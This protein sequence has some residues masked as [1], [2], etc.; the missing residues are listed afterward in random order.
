MAKKKATKKK[1]TKKAA[2]KT[3]AKKASKKEVLIVG[4]KMKDAIRAHGCNV[5]GD[6]IEGLNEY[7][8]W[9]LDQA[10]ARAK[11]NGRKTVRKHD[12]L[13]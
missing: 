3:T 12:I 13:A 10:A 1:A 5:G 4:S 2:K 11:A 7:V 9:A 6:V 8:H